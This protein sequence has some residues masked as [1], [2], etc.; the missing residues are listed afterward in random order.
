MNGSNDGKKLPEKHVN[1]VMFLSVENVVE[2]LLNI[3]KKTTVN[4]LKTSYNRPRI[5]FD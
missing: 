3:I 5:N 4:H 1:E 2:I